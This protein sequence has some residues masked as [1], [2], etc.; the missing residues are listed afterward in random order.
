MVKKPKLI[1]INTIANIK[2]SSKFPAAKNLKL[3]KSATKIKTKII[4]NQ[5]LINSTGENKNYFK[6]QIVNF[7]VRKNSLFPNQKKKKITNL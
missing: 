3:V 4:N 2:L 5:S 1:Y 7:A 6:L